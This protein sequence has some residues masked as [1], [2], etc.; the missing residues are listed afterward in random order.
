MRINPLKGRVAAQRYGK[1]GN[2]KPERR[3]KKALKRLGANFL[4]NHPCKYGEIDILM[5]YEKVAV[6]VDGEIWH[7][8]PQRFDPDILPY[9]SRVAKDIWKKDL[10]NGEYLFAEKTLS[11]ISKFHKRPHDLKLLIQTAMLLYNDR[12]HAADKT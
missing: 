10:R 1:N 9:S 6:F 4:G 3:L 7:A 8:D 5:P 11:I 2:S 12:R